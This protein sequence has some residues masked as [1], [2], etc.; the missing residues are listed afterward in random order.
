MD[1]VY[2]NLG[3]APRVSKFNNPD[4]VKD[5]GYKGMTPHWYVQCGITY[6]KLEEGIVPKGS[7][8]RQWIEKNAIEL[9]KKIKEAKKAGVKL[10][11][12]TD[13]LVVPQSVWKSM[14]KRWSVMNS[15]MRLKTI[16]IGNPTSGKR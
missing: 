13:F 11:P 16:I 5:M 15:G 6:D 9:T 8:E 10:Y 7:E 4:F 12:F 2:N 14:A 3:Q 1:M